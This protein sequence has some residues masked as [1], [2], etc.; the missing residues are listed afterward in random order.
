M[1][2][3]SGLDRVT[4]EEMSKARRHRR[5]ALYCSPCK[6]LELPAQIHCF[7]CRN[8][9]S[10]SEADEGNLGRPFMAVAPSGIVPHW[11]LGNT[12]EGTVRRNGL[13]SVRCGL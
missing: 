10:A 4:K 9:V 12:L 2:V 8:W 7:A 6:A 3:T 5:G 1:N 11:F 13:E